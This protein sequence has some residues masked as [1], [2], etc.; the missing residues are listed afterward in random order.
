MEDTSIVGT[1]K[2]RFLPLVLCNLNYLNFDY[3]NTSSSQTRFAWSHLIREYSRFEVEQAVCDDKRDRYLSVSLSVSRL[4]PS[5][6]ANNI[7]L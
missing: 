4:S 7:S 3:P 5:A 1:L 2:A 6:D